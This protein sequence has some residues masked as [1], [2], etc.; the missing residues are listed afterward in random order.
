MTT[1][2]ILGPMAKRTKIDLRLPVAIAERMKVLADSIGIPANAVY[3]M[4]AAQLVVQLARLTGPSARREAL[5]NAMER[6]FQSIV[7]EIRRT[8]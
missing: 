2:S 5:L 8:A 4:A 6:E 3:A 7:S 1:E